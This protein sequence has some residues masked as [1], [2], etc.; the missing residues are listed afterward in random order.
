MPEALRMAGA[1]V[2]GHTHGEGDL[3]DV[4]HGSLVGVGADQHHPRSHGQADHT[5]TVGVIDM[6]VA[7]LSVSGTLPSPGDNVHDFLVDGFAG[8]TIRELRATM[9]TAPTANTTF[10]VMR[11]GAEVATVTVS[12]GQSEGATTGLS[13]ACGAQDNYTLDLTAGDGSGENALVRVIATVN[14]RAT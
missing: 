14:V 12:A 1:L 7:S 4:S 11:S 10:R 2:P 5:G 6:P 9:K 8:G 3:L 13:V